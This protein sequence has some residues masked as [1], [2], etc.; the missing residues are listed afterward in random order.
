MDKGAEPGNKLPN[1]QTATALAVSFAICKAG[2]Y[3]T[4]LFGIQGGSLP[5]ITAITAILATAFPTH[6][7]HLPPSG[8]AVAMILMQVS[9]T[10]TQ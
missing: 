10:F 3:V 6:F 7:N 5:A 2:S 4:K 1:L 9:L 8:K